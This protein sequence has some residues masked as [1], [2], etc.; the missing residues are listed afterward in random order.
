MPNNEAAKVI[1]KYAYLLKPNQ[2]FQKPTDFQ[3]M[4]SL[5]AWNYARQNMD[6][7]HGKGVTTPIIFQYIPLDK[8]EYAACR[9]MWAVN[10]CYVIEGESAAAKYLEEV[11]K[12]LLAN[13]YSV[14]HHITCPC[15][16]Q[17]HPWSSQEDMAILEPLAPAHMR[18]CCCKGFNHCSVNDQGLRRPPNM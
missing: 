17:D 3:L 5:N 9:R 14:S 7:K 15:K 16:L 13:E 12:D 4:E 8:A 18:G 2:G 6:I 11:V 10:V 1:E